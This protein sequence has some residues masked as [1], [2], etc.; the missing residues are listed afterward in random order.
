M[1]GRQTKHALAPTLLCAPR[2]PPQTAYGVGSCPPPPD[3]ELLN[4]YS[5]SFS[6]FIPII[7]Y[8]NTR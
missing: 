1:T 8:V 4:S 7:K 5:C 2:A 6:T 3:H